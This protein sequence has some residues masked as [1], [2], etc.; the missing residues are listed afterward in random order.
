MP[1]GINQRR[2]VD[3]WEGVQIKGSLTKMPGFSSRD[4]VPGKGLFASRCYRGRAYCSQA[5]TETKMQL[6]NFQFT[7]PI[8]LQEPYGE[9]NV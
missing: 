2:G 6:I 3:E 5:K 1:T 7:C 8:L 9:V 4:L